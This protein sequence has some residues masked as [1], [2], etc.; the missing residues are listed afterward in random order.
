MTN[1]TTMQMI[2]RATNWWAD[3]SWNVPFI[4]ELGSWDL[5]LLPA[6]QLS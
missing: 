2:V 4:I 3:Y 5:L 1:D 6:V